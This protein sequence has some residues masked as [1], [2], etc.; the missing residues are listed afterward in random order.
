MPSIT[1][2]TAAATLTA[3]TPAIR[4]R[5]VDATRAIAML[6]VVV[7]HWLVALPT[8]GVG[9]GI[10]GINAIEKLHSFQ[11]LT[12]IFQ[13]MP[14]VF[15]VGGF[16]NAASLAT[17]RARGGR[18]SAWVAS[19]L[20]RL[21]KPTIVF[22]AFWG[23]LRLL[24]GGSGLVATAAHVAAVPL[25]FLAV[26]V[27]VVAVQPLIDRL[28]NG[29]RVATLVCLVV[30]SLVGDLAQITPGLGVVAWLNHIWV[31]AACQQLGVLWFEGRMP[32]GRRAFVAALAALGTAVG[33]VAFGPW[34]LS[35]V[36]VSGQRMSN[37]HPPS[38]IL[39]LMG[40]F[41]ICAVRSIE[42][43]AQR[44]LH[45]PKVWMAVALINL[46]I[47]T[48]YLWHFTAL[49]IASV[50]V[51]PLGM[52]PAAGLGST[53]WWLTRPLWY[54][55]LTALLVGIV[56]LVGRFESG[57]KAA[58]HPVVLLAIVP[59]ASLALFHITDNGATALAA[60]VLLATDRILARTV[61]AH[62]S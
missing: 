3:A 35:L 6:A 36:Y 9:G 28:W 55:M 43:R 51:I 2:P 61:P 17:A 41:Q 42:A 50:I 7:G 5:V 49:I 56:A 53:S 1:S 21:L 27:V 39:L 34:S 29:H 45:K 18:D 22:A 37:A 30:L 20:R 60:V 48:V 31:F 59:V 15:V 47:M 4:N 14:L 23:G 16:A 52:R 57:G 11:Y 54:A 10:G 62:R 8:P 32:S 19:R 40:V 12:W 44:W 26:Y 25:W 33:L 24:A 38:I 13:V 58:A 46:R